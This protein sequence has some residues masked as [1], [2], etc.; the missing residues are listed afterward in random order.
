[1]AV[2]FHSSLS[3]NQRYSTTFPQRGGFGAPQSQPPW[4]EPRKPWI[5]RSSFAEFCQRWSIQQILKQQNMTTCFNAGRMMNIYQHNIYLWT[6]RWQN[7]AKLAKHVMFKVII[8]HNIPR[9]DIHITK[10]DMTWYILVG[11]WATPLKNMSQLG[12]WHSQYM[13]K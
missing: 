2:F 8:Q 6:N 13:K 9:Q 7:S 10:H 12:W 4:W 3:K 11:G 1:M 5:Q